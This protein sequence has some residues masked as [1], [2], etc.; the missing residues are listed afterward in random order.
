SW[1]STRYVVFCMCSSTYTTQ[2]PYFTFP[3]PALPRSVFFVSRADRSRVVELA[4]LVVRFDP[5][6]GVHESQHRVPARKGG[7]RAIPA[8]SACNTRAS[9]RPSV[10]GGVH[11]FHAFPC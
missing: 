5:L 11:A 8:V 1:R 2:H 10:F 3:R 6:D 4:H 9:I 7:L